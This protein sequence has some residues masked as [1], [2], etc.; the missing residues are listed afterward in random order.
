MWQASAGFLY[1]S[2]GVDRL[3]N[4]QQFLRKRIA[5]VINP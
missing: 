1:Q 3:V 5:G 4:W 2:T